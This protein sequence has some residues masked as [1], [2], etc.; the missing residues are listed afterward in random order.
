MPVPDG[1]DL[2]KATLCILV[3]D[4]RILLAMKKRGF[5]IGK[6]N[7]V[8]GKQ[9]AGEDVKT[10]AVRE[11]KEEIG[12]VPISMRKVAVLN[13]YF[14][15]SPKDKDWNQQVHIFLVDGWD[16][17]PKETEEM[18][19]EWF[20]LDKIPYESM[21]DDDRHWLPKVL[22][23]KSIEGDFIFDRDQKLADF[24]MKEVARL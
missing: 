5:G 18:N 23:G 16:G 6:W 2:R 24:K 21:W 20:A 12:V 7:G 9:E 17:T 1:K 19:P 14:P 3:S 22:E 15:E 13:F 10:T 8:G 11:T 4:G